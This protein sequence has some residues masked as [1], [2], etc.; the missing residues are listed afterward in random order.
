MSTLR[1]MAEAKKARIMA[2]AER[3][4]AQVDR[5]MEQLEQLAAKYGLSVTEPAPETMQAAEPPPEADTEGVRTGLLRRRFPPRATNGAT[6]DAILEEA[7][8]DVADASVTKR[9]R[10]A[11][12]AYIRAKKRPVPLAELDEVLVAKEIRFEVGNSRESTLSAVLGQDPA[13]HV[14]R[15]RAGM[16]AS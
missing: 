4:A 10:V 6:A 1:K 16:V 13:L 9:A 5:D 8:K 14:P 15:P 2:E 11:A 7:L 12:V 3:E